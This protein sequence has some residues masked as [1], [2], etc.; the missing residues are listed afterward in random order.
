MDDAPTDSASSGRRQGVRE[1][2]DDEGRGETEAQRVDRNLVELLQE[3][4]VASIGVQVLFGFLLSIPFTTQFS[5]LSD[6][7]HVLYVV[8]LVLAAI[9]TA[10]FVAPVAHHRLLFRRHAKERVLRAAN[11]AAIAGLVAV[12]LTISGSVLLV[13][14]FVG[15]AVVVSLVA[16]PMATVIFALWFVFPLVSH[17]RDDY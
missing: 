3:L 13:V 11:V 10:L 2:N 8:D 6:K 17:H 4:R 16:A 12:G 15:N 9:A 14:S 5:R 7:Q 1:A